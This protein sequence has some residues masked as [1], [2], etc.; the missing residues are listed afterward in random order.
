MFAD[1]T[2]AFMVW[3][4]FSSK[5]FAEREYIMKQFLQIFMFL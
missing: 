2:L 3:V 5:Y 1:C 4:N